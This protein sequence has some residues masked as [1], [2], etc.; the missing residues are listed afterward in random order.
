MAK[1]R[2]VIGQGLRAALALAVGLTVA[3]MVVVTTANYRARSAD[4]ALLLPTTT[5]LEIAQPEEQLLPLES[6]EDDPKPT[7]FVVEL[8]DE[9]AIDL[10][11]RPDPSDEQAA[12]PLDQ[13]DEAL[14]AA[15]QEERQARSEEM[16]RLREEARRA[17]EA[18]QRD[19]LA[20]NE[21][22]IEEDEDFDDEEFDDEDELDD[23]EEDDEEESSPSPLE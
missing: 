15:R 12:R 1:K 23:E 7:H 19:M 17:Q 16:M 22:G 9:P 11:D 14:L 21:A 18:Y 5:V 8:I 20:Q 10:A 6:V 2:V 4:G 13:Q 3:I